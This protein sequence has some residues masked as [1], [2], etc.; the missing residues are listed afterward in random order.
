MK[1][2][3]CILSAASSQNQNWRK[4]L[5]CKI[6][7]LPPA[8]REDI[9]RLR[10]SVLKGAQEH[11]LQPAPQLFSPPSI[12][13]SLHTTQILFPAPSSRPPTTAAQVPENQRARKGTDDLMDSHIT[14]FCDRRKTD[15]VELP[16]LSE[17]PP[18]RGAVSH[19]SALPLSALPGCSL[20]KGKASTSSA[21]LLHAKEN[22][23]QRHP[24]RVVSTSKAAFL[25]I[26][27]TSDSYGK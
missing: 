14:Q 6:L 23:A 27:C 2:T 21:A 4:S 24:Q 26:C 18:C 25:T 1:S 20:W 11:Q 7:Q 15:R 12:F 9:R 13:S 16:S 17:H 8:G 22:R 19:P 3:R 10:D 5:G